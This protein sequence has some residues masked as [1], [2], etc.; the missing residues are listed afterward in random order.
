MFSF[1]IKALLIHLTIALC[2]RKIMQKYWFS[3]DDFWDNCIG[4]IK[5]FQQSRFKAQS[6]GGFLSFYER[7]KRTL[8]IFYK[9][10]QSA[11][12]FF[13]LQHRTRT[14]LYAPHTFSLHMERI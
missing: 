13:K 4:F 12:E 11:F 14:S 8:F 2:L 5:K 3:I 9:P 6:Q 10:Q 1:I 7:S